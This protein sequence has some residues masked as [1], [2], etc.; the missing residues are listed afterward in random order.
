MT[1]LL[2]HLSTEAAA[3][4]EAL[5]DADLDA[6]V[7]GCPDWVLRDLVLHT[8]VV[9]RWA[10]AVVTTGEKQPQSEPVVADDQLQAWFA[11]GAELLVPALDVA[12]DRPC[13]TL[14]GPG[15][16]L[17]WQRRQAVETA[18]HRVDA[19]GCRSSPQPVPAEL[20]E[21]GVEEVV[22]VL[23][24]RQVRLGR[25]SPATASVELV[26]TSGRRWQLGEGPPCGVVRASASDLLLLLW[27]RRRPDEDG[28]DVEA[29]LPVLHALLAS[30]LTP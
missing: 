4:G 16:A 17:F 28:Y 21:V 30:G 8:G 23:H 7:P 26:A 2:A 15:T 14:S 13:W 24:P 6:P 29:D 19:Q 11:E 20:A 18:V 27:Q 25:T 3:M 12:P 5:Q 1:D 10:A 9:H 22:E